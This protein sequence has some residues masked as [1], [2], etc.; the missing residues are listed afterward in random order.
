MFRYLN[1][2]RIFRYIQ[3]IFRH[4]VAVSK[5]YN[6]PVAQIVREQIALNRLNGMRRDE[7]YKYHLFD[8]ALSWAERC[9]FVSDVEVRKIQN[10]LNP[11][12][13]HYL[14]KNKLIFK[15]FFAHAGIP[16]VDDVGLFDPAW[17]RTATGE[18]LCGAGDIE[19]LIASEHANNGLVF[20]PIE[21]S[22]GQMVMVFP[23]TGQGYLYS[24]S[25]E[26]VDAK[27]LEE[28]LCDPVALKR[29]YSGG[30]P[31]SAFLVESCVRGH[32]ELESICGETLCTCRLVTLVKPGG[33]VMLLGAVFKLA[34]ST[35]GV[36]NLHAGGLSVGV[37]LESGKLGKGRTMADMW[38]PYRSSLP[39]G[40]EFEHTTLPY[41]AETKELAVRS[42]LAFPLLPCVGWDIAITDQGPV[43]IEGN[44]GW[45]ADL[46]QIGMHR[47]VGDELRQV[48]QC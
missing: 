14:L 10:R 41:W 6:I 38:K 24:I 19:R 34:P 46:M 7:Y 36:D 2:F 8:P 37:D 12:Q 48:L 31:Q 27:T 17:G 26:K 23:R 5:E 33:E 47:G 15:R 3:D 45:A 39:G 42:A 43:V 25:G 32:R 21:G 22:E 9:A 29:A 1:P 35:A 13:Y 4:A 44:W 16:V 40:A 30:D 20:K 11:P 18:P 28:R